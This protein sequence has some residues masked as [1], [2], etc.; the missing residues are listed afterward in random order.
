MI[1]TVLLRIKI[2]VLYLA[3]TVQYVVEN[4][5]SK[6]S[7]PPSRL[8]PAAF[9]GRESVGRSLTR[10]YYLRRSYTGQWIMFVIFSQQNH[11]L[12]NKDTLKLWLHM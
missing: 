6:Q 10:V 3:S 8:C 4:N 9:R 5:K 7:P 11:F 12:T 2:I 1:T